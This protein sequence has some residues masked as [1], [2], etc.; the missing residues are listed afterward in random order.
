LSARDRLTR[1]VRRAVSWR[2][3]GPAVLTLVV[4]AEVGGRTSPPPVNLVLWCFTIAAL[5]V[6]AKLAVWVATSYPTFTRDERLIVVIVILA[7]A[8][9][10][11]A[12]RTWAF[13][14]QFDDF[15]ATQN[16]NFKLTL[17][18]LS[19]R[20][21]VFV[22]DRARHAPAPPK[23]ET[24]DRDEDDIMRYQHDAQIEFEAVFGRQVRTAH[25]VLAQFGLTDRDFERFYRHPADTFEMRVVATKLAFFSSKIPLD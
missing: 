9:S 1:I 20:I 7:T 15:V 8:G 13:E 19:G 18:E 2:Y 16:L 11:Y 6:L 21:L 22:S 12:A 24:W 14:R 4:L 25:D 5:V 3:V 23:P 10:W 17:N